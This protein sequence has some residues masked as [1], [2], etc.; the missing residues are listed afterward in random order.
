MSAFEIGDVVQ[1]KSGGQRMTVEEVGQDG[2]ISCVWFDGNR[3]ER[4]AFLEGTLM[5]YVSM[6]ASIKLQ[7]S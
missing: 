5:K 4:Q 1:L 2:F 7:R 6:A 3:S